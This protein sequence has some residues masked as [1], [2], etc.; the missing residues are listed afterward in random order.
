[1]WQERERERERESLS[2]MSLKNE[3]SLSRLFQSV[4]LESSFASVARFS[5]EMRALKSGRGLVSYPPH[6]LCMYC[7]MNL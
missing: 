1:M 4:C 6:T 2:R 3:S 5:D 7:S